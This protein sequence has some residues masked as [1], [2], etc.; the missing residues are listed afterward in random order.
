MKRLFDQISLTY[1]NS[2]SLGLLNPY[3]HAERFWLELTL[4]LCLFL[5]SVEV[6][7]DLEGWLKG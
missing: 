4:S 2:D 5:S 7:E 6:S 3:F 1:Q